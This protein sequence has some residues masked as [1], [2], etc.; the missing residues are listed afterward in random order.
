MTAK[1]NPVAL[2]HVAIEGG[3]W[4]A[5]VETNRTATLPIEYDQLKKTGRLD[6]WKLEWKEGQLPRPHIFWD[7]D[8]AKWIEAAAYSLSS[9]AD[10]GLEQLIDAAVDLME[11]A[12]QPDGYM[13]TYFTIVEPDKRWT[14]LRDWHEL[15]CAGHLM[16]GAVAYFQATGKRQFLDIMCRY[17]DHSDRMFGPGEGQKRGYPGHEE[18]ELA[19]VKLYRATNDK[20]YLD[21]AQ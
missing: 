15:Y 10:P 13:N 12:Q 18:L 19:L 3:F 6:V 2:N 7:S 1:L 14:N 9:H 4:G 8:V 20:R 21:L 11:K 17:A 5:R 16:E